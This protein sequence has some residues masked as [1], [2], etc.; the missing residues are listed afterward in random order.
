M[1]F[2]WWNLTV[3]ENVL[4]ITSCKID[5]KEIE[6]F[7]LSR[8][9]Y[10]IFLAKRPIRIVE[11]AYSRVKNCNVMNLPDSRAGDPGAS[12]ESLASA[13]RAASACASAAARSSC[14]CWSRLRSA[15]SAASWRLLISLS[16]N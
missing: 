7:A 1:F 6:W 11:H 13:D 12:C 2:I 14:S 15:S 8:I 4:E 9:C 3:R 16:S 10:S 5:A